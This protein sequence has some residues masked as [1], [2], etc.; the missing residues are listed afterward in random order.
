MSFTPP[1]LSRTHR[2][3]PPPIC[4]TAILP[5]LRPPVFLIPSVK[6]IKGRPFHNSDLSIITV[7]LSDGVIGRNRLSFSVIAALLEAKPA[8]AKLLNNDGND[9]E[10]PSAGNRFD[11]TGRCGACERSEPRG[12]I[13]AGRR[14]RARIKAVDI[15]IVVYIW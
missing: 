12:A 13:G 6:A 2:L 10:E 3:C 5:R 7:C 4:L 14:T 1:P 8:R 11:A 9:N 15:R